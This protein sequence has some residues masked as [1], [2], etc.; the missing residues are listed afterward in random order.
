M[1]FLGVVSA[2][3][4]G[5]F[6]AAAPAAAAP[7]VVLSTSPTSN[8]LSAPAATPISVT[9]D[10]ALMTSSVTAQTLHVFGKQTGK[11][12]GTLSFSNGNQTVTFTPAK[13]FAAGELVLVNLSHDIKAADSTPLRSAGY[14]FQFLIRTAPALR[15]FDQAQSMSNRSGS[16]TRIYGAAAAD[17]NG[18]GF[19]DLATVNEDSADI[20]VF[21]NK[22]DGSG[23]YDEKFTKPFPIGVE[24]S[25]N[26]TLDF[27]DD[28]KIDLAVSATDSGGVWIV[29]GAGNGKWASSQVVMT[30]SEAHGIATL[31]I[32]GDGDLDIVDAL[33]G[34]SSDE[35]AVL[36][37]NAGT[38][39]NPTY[40]ES[41][42][43]GDWG[44][45]S[46]DVNGDGIIDLVVGCTVEEKISVMLGNGDGSFTALTPQDAGGSPWQVTLGDVDGDGDLDVTLANAFPTDGKGGALLIGNGDGTYGAPARFDTNGHAPATDLGDLDGDGDLDWV[47]SGHVGGLWR[48]YVNDGAGNFTF[49]QDFIATDNPS[50]AVLLDIDNDGDLDMALTDEIADVVVVLR[51]AAGPSPLCPPAPDDCRLPVPGKSSFQ[52]VDKTPD[53][54]DKLTW[55]WAG[56]D[57][58]AKGDYGD[59]LATDDYALCVYD[60]GNL[61]M[62][63]T[64]DHGGLCGKKGCWKDGKSGFTYADKLLTPTGMKKLA[65]TAGASAGKPKISA[66]G[67]GFPLLMPA[68][69]DIVGPVDV[70]LQKSSGGPC[71]G[72]TFSAP[73]TKTG[74]AIFKDKSN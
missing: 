71:F 28:G 65:L 11:S 42:C 69:G 30:G 60:D 62:S 61:I 34:P 23:T 45:A 56:A 37:N 44:L 9:F 72:A 41:G 6:L 2:I 43:T 26:E 55:K 39:S 14:A 29:R 22:A 49:D 21:M 27:D 19:I 66:A 74:T 18:D 70:Q 54:S 3:A 31:D 5:V 35:M 67:K 17:L 7:P 33:A 48:L 38:F 20:R 40:F 50:C 1:R 64:A 16:P 47:L 46:G 8:S 24:S 59:P 52:L 13:A 53:K 73:F 4:A 68:L 58:T 36:V 10:Q 32:D 63:T 51:N 12:T 15:S 57:A 25:P